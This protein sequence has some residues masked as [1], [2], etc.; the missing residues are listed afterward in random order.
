MPHYDTAISSKGRLT[1]PSEL[2]QSLSIEIGEDIKWIDC[3][4]YPALEIWEFRHRHIEEENRKHGNPPGTGAL[5][6][7]VKDRPVL[8][9]EEMDEAVHQ[10]VIENYERKLMEQS[11]GYMTDVPEPVLLDPVLTRITTKGQITMPESYRRK[12]DMHEGDTVVLNDETDHL[13]V[14]KAEDILSRVAG[15]LSAYAGNGPLE[16]DREQL[17]TGITRER[18]ERI[19]RQASEEKDNQHDIG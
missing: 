10:G 14:Q 8:T 19:W 13:S 3:G 11:E 6:D 7:Y 4:D 15:S 12:Y 1:L 2:R 18:E 5:R 16:I 17:W 9:I